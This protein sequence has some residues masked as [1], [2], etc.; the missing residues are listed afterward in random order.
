MCL[1]YTWSLAYLVGIRGI[2]GDWH[3]TQLV[4]NTRK[5]FF[6]IYKYDLFVG[7]DLFSYAFLEIKTLQ[8]FETLF[9]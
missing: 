3:P 2:N 1:M 9:S 7:D 5:Q 4:S 6:M 8:K